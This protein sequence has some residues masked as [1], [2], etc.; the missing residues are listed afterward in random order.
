MSGATFFGVQ[1]YF[2][3]KDKGSYVYVVDFRRMFILQ[4]Y[5][6]FPMTFWTATALAQHPNQT[7]KATNG[8]GWKEKKGRV[9]LRR[10][11]RFALG[12]AGR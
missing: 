8:E 2:K 11:V 6:I 10:L 12:V 5:N 4:L 3:Y 9:G 1:T 7:T